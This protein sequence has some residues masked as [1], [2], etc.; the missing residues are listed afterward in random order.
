MSRCGYVEADMNELQTKDG[1]VTQRRA[2][3]QWV[4]KEVS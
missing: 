4:R 3:I 2:Q 1:R